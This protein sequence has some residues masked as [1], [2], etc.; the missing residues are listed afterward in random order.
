MTL[1]DRLADAQ[2]RSVALYLRMQSL[3]AQRQQIVQAFGL[4]QQDLL[5][6]DGEITAL[7]AALGDTNAV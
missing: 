1:A 5:K 2:Q 3:E 7:T 6:V 4:C